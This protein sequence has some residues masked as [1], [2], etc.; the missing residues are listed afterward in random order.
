MFDEEKHFYTVSEI[1]AL[2]KMQ[3]EARFPEI[4]LEG[5]IS[6]FRPSGAGHCYFTLK[7]SHSMI[8]AVMFRGE[9]S[10]LAFKPTDGTKVKVSGRITLYAQRGNYQIICSS[11]E[12]QGKGNILEIL[13]RRKRK[14]AAEGLFDSQYKKEIPRFPKQVV[15]ITSPTGA[16]IRDILQVMKRRNSSIQVRILPCAVQGDQSARQIKK[17]IET[18]NYHKMG[19]L[20]IVARGGGS[21]EDLMAFSE[22]EVV[23]AISSSYIPVITGI[24]H[25]IDFSLSDFAADLRAPTPS[26]AA[27]L[28]SES[29]S[30]TLRI[31]E[32]YKHE[33]TFSIR[34]RLTLLR[35]RLKPFA[36][37]EIIL[38]FR[39]YMDP[40][41]IEVDD[42]KESIKKNLD[43]ELF[44]Q[45]HKI[46]LFKKE[47][48]GH[49]P[50]E[51]M[52]K[53]YSLVTDPS[54]KTISNTDQIQ[55]GDS[56]SIR[57]ARGKAKTTV[58]EKE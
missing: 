48:M 26:A 49:S 23:R 30:E 14:L 31:I 13:E 18:A 44:R 11:M 20:I 46:E 10:K 58:E 24:G 32:K 27:E 47:L 6:N 37:E 42:L 19:D 40:L 43:D 12:E 51:I 45:K 3:L 39:R 9:A 8:Q 21:L 55:K 41:I 2:I 29:S 22:E 5:E 52:K 7:D 4:L 50:L 56:L 16:A 57:F 34:S 36:K 53:G 54:G 33:M 17:M 1:T 38:H 25:E 15:V 28:V 35:E